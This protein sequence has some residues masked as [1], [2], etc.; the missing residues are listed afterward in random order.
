MAEQPPPDQ[1]DGPSPVTMLLVAVLLVAGGYLLSVKLA[2]MN[3]LQECV[4]SGRT[5]CAPVATPSPGG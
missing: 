3:R 1:D 4:M 2:E 5:N